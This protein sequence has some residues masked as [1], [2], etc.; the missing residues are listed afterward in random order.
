[1]E[2]AVAYLDKRERELSTVVHLTVVPRRERVLADLQLVIQSTCAF[3]EQEA[4]EPLVRRNQLC[5]T[6]IILHSA[7]FFRGIVFNI[8]CK[9]ICFASSVCWNARPPNLR[10]SSMLLMKSTLPSGD[11]T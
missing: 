5:A 10:I 3:A 11:V 1:M 8:P 6:R 7:F 2:M 9:V 4:D